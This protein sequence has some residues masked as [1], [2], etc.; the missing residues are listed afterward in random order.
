MQ[1]EIPE[2]PKKPERQPEPAVAPLA[3]KV[4]AVLADPTRYKIY[5]W[6]LTA[7]HPVTVSEAA[8]EFKIHP[9]VARMHLSKLAEIDLLVAEAQKTGKGGRPGFVY[10]PSGQAVSLTVAPRDFHLLADLL[11]QSLA[12]M[13][14]GAKDAVS[15]I[16]R[17]FGRRLA[18]EALDTIG[19]EP[20][21]LEESI[22]ACAAALQRLGVSVAVTRSGDGM[23]HLVMRTCGFQ[24]VATAHP[25]Q[26]C[27]LCA[28]MVEGISQA[29]LETQPEV[30]QT[31]TRPRG[32]SE[33]VYE[34]GGLI[35]LE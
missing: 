20:A 10:N 2:T 9:N 4:G 16:G 7:T 26:I 30:S 25:E 27:L 3:Q 17:T 11:V 13:G 29:C 5:Q 23:A 8:R 32:S 35:P 18:N 33:C 21:G 31:A 15:Q 34:V 12:L 14:D 19:A 6:V 22:K 28:A 24:E 1:R